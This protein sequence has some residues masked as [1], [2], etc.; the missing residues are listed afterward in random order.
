M[1]DAFLRN[2]QMA[3]TG[4]FLSRNPARMSCYRDQLRQA[5][6]ELTSLV[7]FGIRRLEDQF[8]PPRSVVERTGGMCKTFRHLSS[9]TLLYRMG[10]RIV[11]FM[12]YVVAVHVNH[13]INKRYDEYLPDKEYVVK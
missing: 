3:N 4:S 8:A 2:T 13:I 5:E 7:A 10:R 9:G 11:N 12:V 6:T 1:C